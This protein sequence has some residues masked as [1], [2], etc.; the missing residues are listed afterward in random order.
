MIKRK[1]RHSSWLKLNRLTCISLNSTVLTWVLIWIYLS[2]LCCLFD[3][4]LVHEGFVHDQKQQLMKGFCS[5]VI[6][7]TTYIIGLIDILGCIFRNSWKTYSIYVCLDIINPLINCA[8]LWI[9]CIKT[10]ILYDIVW[11]TN[12]GL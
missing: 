10:R 12:I 1:I 4:T 8:L 2:D 5:F 9:Y 7:D 11:Y 6:S 3:N